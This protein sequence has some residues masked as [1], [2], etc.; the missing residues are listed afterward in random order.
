M[1]ITRILFILFLGLLLSSCSVQTERFSHPWLIPV[2]QNIGMRHEWKH[3]NRNNYAYVMPVAMEKAVALLKDKKLIKLSSKQAKF[4]TNKKFSSKNQLF[5]IRGVECLP[6]NNVT[7]ED[8]SVSMKRKESALLVQD[9]IYDYCSNNLKN[10][11]MVVSLDF[12]PKALYVIVL[13]PV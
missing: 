1:M 12:I 7:K 3:L 10:S 2:D 11:A 13:K 5:L 6:A 9:V 4:Y 8:F